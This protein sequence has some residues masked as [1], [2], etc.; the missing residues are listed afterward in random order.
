MAKAK[1]MSPRSGISS[2]IKRIACL[3]RPVSDEQCH[4]IEGHRSRHA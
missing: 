4:L 1:D 3:L 2:D